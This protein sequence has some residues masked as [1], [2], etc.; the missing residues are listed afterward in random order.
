MT[1]PLMPERSD[2]YVG[3]QRYQ[4]IDLAKLIPLNILQSV[5]Y[6]LRILLENVALRSPES[7]PS[8]LRMM[9]GE[10]A[11]EEV[12][13]YPDRLMFHD[14]TCLPALADFA[15]MRD[16]TAEL[17]GDARAINPHIPAV[18]TIDHSV[19]VESYASSDALED[20]LQFDFRRN[21]ERYRFIR[22]AEQSL[23]NFRV[24]PPGTGIIHLMNLEAIAEVATVDEREV[25]PLI[26]A[27][28]MIATDS[29][30]P[31]INA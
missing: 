24:I 14:T 30:T 20:N 28:Y 9:A 7:L 16:L 21:A 22:W 17:G 2:L 25:V 12:E 3:G 13:F 19:I 29:H 8:F 23:D 1:S 11:Y 5:P 27:D 10:A 6:S 15:A 26:H 4:F 18:L 31:M